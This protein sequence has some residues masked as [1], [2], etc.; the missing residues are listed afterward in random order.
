MLKLLRR[1]QFLVRYRKHAADLD[2]EMA[3]H[4]E[5]LAQRSAGEG[6][7]AHRS[8]GGGG[9]VVKNRELRL[10]SQPGARVAARA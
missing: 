2:E 6:G 7:P 4:R 8:L 3:F 1:L 5:M 10:A 9:R